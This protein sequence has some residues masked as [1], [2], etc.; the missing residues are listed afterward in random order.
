MTENIGKKV[1]KIYLL[2]YVALVLL[3]VILIAFTNINFQ[4]K[5]INTRVSSIINLSFYV[6][7]VILYISLFTGFWKKVGI[8]FKQNFNEYLKLI[9]IGF[10]SLVVVSAFVSISYQA[11]GLTDQSD[12]QA[13]LEALLAGGL[14][15]KLSLIIFA[16]FLAPLVEEMVFRMATFQI[17]NRYTSLN[18]WLIIILSSLAFGLIH[19]VSTLDFV[20]LPYYAGLGLL[21]GFFY[22]KSKNILVP[23]TIHMLL[24][25]FVTITMFTL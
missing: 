8:Q 9:I 13:A 20:Q 19:V 21:L 16:V 23:I 12:N 5:Q 11:L 24:N 17:L 14:F 3:Q 25:A 18:H 22:Y 1:I 6:L 2:M 10:I 7:M 15:D 4:D